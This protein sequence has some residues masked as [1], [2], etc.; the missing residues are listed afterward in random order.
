LAKDRRPSG[1]QAEIKDTLL[2]VR[3]PMTLM[4][5]IDQQVDA[6]RSEAPWVTMTRS[7][8]VR[9]LLGIALEHE[10][11]RMFGARRIDE[12]PRAAAG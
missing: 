7:D 12:P 1:R 6:M 10:R 11:A 9:W 2:A 3:M 5:Q 8:A 4:Q